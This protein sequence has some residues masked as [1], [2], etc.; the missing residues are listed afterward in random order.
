MGFRLRENDIRRVEALNK[1]SARSGRTVVY[2]FWG[3]GMNNPA[4]RLHINHYTA[5]SVTFFDN[6][7]KIRVTQAAPSRL[8][9]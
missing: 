3:G 6:V 5:L 2:V 8:V 4:Y 9:P 7:G 1:P